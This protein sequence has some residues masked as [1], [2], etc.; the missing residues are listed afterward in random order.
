MKPGQYNQNSGYILIEILV[1]TL[2]IGTFLL[3]IILTED[4]IERMFFHNTLKK[5]AVFSI[6]SQMERLSALYRWCKGFNNPFY[7]DIYGKNSETLNIYRN[8]MLDSSCI[9][10]GSL[11]IT[12]P[13]DV[14]DGINDWEE[15]Y[16][17][18]DISNAYNSV[19]IDKQRHIA[20]KIEWEER[21]V[22]DCKLCVKGTECV[23]L[24]R[25]NAVCLILKMYYPYRWRDNRIVED[26][27]LG[28]KEE[29]V[30]KTIVVRK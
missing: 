14:L 3:V 25:A 27:A 8:G 6:N 30:L 19:F 1:S 22:N 5:R 18:P 29:L 21:S 9:A 15:I 7:K 24:D 26:E 20:A 2:L 10:N 28:K 13:F 16:Y 11:V 12:N 23:T 4:V 17:N